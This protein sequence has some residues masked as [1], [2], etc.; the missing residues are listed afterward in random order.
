[1]KTPDVPRLSAHGAEIPA[2]GFGTS[3]RRRTPARWWRPRSRPATATSTPRGNTAPSARVGEAMRASGVPREE[4]FLTTKVS[5][6][7][8]RA[9]DFARSVDE[10]LEGAAASTMSICCWCTGRT[11]RFRSPRRCRRWPRRSGRASRATSASRISTS[12]CSTRRSQLC[13]EPLVALQAEYHPYLDQT[14]AA[15]TRA[16]R[17]GMA[18]IAYCPLGRGR[19]FSDPVLGEI[20]H[21][22][23]PARVAQIALRWLMQQG[24][25]R[26]IP[27]SSNPQR[28]ADNLNVFDF[29]LSDDEMKRIAALKRPDG[30]I[31]NPSGRSRRRG[32]DR[33]ANSELAN[34][35]TARAS[36]CF[37]TRYSLL[38]IRATIDAP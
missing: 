38:A 35:R 28:I 37:P 1:M 12:R 33:A 30:R 36:R 15:R 13:P 2:L 18:F 26:A 11:R 23:R 29:A 4:I 25:S 34:R 20:A 17:A 27:R 9:A 6:E 3:D 7:Y 19:L 16:A 8:L 31:A 10:S 32:I 22:A 5:H 21:A 14:Q 24:T